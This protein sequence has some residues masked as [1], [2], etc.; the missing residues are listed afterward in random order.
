MNKSSVQVCEGLA[1]PFFENHSNV[2][3]GSSNWLVA[4]CGFPS[5]INSY[6]FWAK[7]SS[8][9][10]KGRWTTIKISSPATMR[11]ALAWILWRPSSQVWNQTNQDSARSHQCSNRCH[12][13]LSKRLRRWQT[14]THLLTNFT[15]TQL[16]PDVKTSGSRSGTLEPGKFLISVSRV[17]ILYWKI[18]NQMIFTSWI[19]DGKLLKK[20][21]KLNRNSSKRIAFNGTATKKPLLRYWLGWTRWKRLWNRTPS[22]SLLLT[23]S[24]ASCS[25]RKYAPL[26]LP[27]SYCLRYCLLAFFFLIEDGT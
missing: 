9:A 1:F 17:W 13:S 16:L 21:L 14:C 10:G 7:K 26:F 12:Q 20:V 5:G 19:S 8:T 18:V 3:Y 23:T 11:P 22:Q 25:N 2:V 6:T 4:I 27:K 15:R 24:A